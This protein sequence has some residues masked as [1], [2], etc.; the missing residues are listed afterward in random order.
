M[1][2][3]A[4]KS[5]APEPP[6]P[7]GSQPAPT[8]PVYH[9]FVVPDATPTVAI[10]LIQ[11]KA[12]SG[13]YVACEGATVKA[14]TA[15]S[16][17]SVWK[18]ITMRT[19]DGGVLL[20]IKKALLS[21]VDKKLAG[22]AE[23]HPSYAIYGKVKVAAPSDAPPPASSGGGLIS[24]L[25]AK[26]GAALSAASEKASDAASKYLDIDADA[27]IVGTLIRTRGVSKE[28]G[29]TWQLLE[30]KVAWEHLGKDNSPAVLYELTEV[31]ESAQWTIRNA[32]GTLVG[33]GALDKTWRPAEGVA[34][35]TPG[36][37]FASMRIELGAGVDIALVLAGIISIDDFDDK[38]YNGEATDAVMQ[39]GR[40]VTGAMAAVD[41][42]LHPGDAAGGA[43][44]S[45]GK[46]G[47]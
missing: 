18:T 8:K 24:G 47:K 42:V 25:V 41:R 28:P 6:E 21:E 46:G 26:T 10:N 33:R 7:I 34:T 29:A 32:K 1:G 38:T 15:S 40:S 14:T 45:A 19:A 27:D 23:E 43:A 4:S 11:T 37:N 30:G 12:A 2:C 35:V 39:L 31:P 9:A 17:S 20:K 22:D 36:A 13:G 44:D 3:G 16:R 5:V